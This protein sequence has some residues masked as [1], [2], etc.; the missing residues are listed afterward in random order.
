[1]REKELENSTETQNQGWSTAHVEHIWT[2]E[3]ADQHI[4]LSSRPRGK[5]PTERKRTSK[6]WTPI[7]VPAINQREIVS[8]LPHCLQIIGEQKLLPSSGKLDE[9]HI[10]TVQS[11]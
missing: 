5:F 3:E 1:M 7:Q 6:L 10:L 8:N 2:A 4:Q 11:K 9:E